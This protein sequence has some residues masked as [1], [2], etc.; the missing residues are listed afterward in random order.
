[1][2][3]RRPSLP[4][5]S[6]SV[7]P[8]A[9][10]GSVQGST[11]RPAGSRC[12]AGPPSCPWLEVN[13]EGRGACAAPAAPAARRA[14]EHRSA[15]MRGEVEGSPQLCSA[16]S[17]IFP[18]PFPLPRFCFWLFG[19][20]RRAPCPP[21][22][23][24]GCPRAGLSP[25]P[26]AGWAA[27]SRAVRYGSAAGGYGSCGSLSLSRPSRLSPRPRSAVSPAKDPPGCRGTGA[28]RPQ[29]EVTGF[30]R[31][32]AGAAAEWGG[33]VGEPRCAGWSAAE[34]ASLGEPS[35]C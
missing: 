30:A 34:G 21:W 1:M 7:L 18:F 24:S 5:L 17:L 28:R 26:A 19:V 12:A 27:R 16:E 22:V 23:I 20:S 10:F 2:R 9:P 4:S 35:R 6:W 29:S 13:G 11:T 25:S 15:L 14:A 32:A 3:S 33:G 31:C 8:T